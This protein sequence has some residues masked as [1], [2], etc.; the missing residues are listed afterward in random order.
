[1]KLQQTSA[2]Q[3]AS[4]GVR[5]LSIPP[6]FFGLYLLIRQA[7]PTDWRHLT[8]S[9]LAASRSPGPATLSRHRIALN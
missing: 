2:F 1:L 5:A 3:A 4:A 7:V 6:T 8:A 9:A